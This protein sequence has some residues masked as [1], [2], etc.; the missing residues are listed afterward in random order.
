MSLGEAWPLVFVLG[1]LAVALCGIVINLCALG[2]LE[3]LKVGA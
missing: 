3:L 1:P 2:V